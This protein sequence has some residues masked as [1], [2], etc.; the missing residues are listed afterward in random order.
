MALAPGSYVGVYEIL[1]RLDAGGMGEVYRARDP[2]LRRQVA[3]KV[4]P[5]A[6]ADDP[7]RLARFEREAQAVA[8]LSHPNILAIHD[9]GREGDIT[10]AVMEL[11][12]GHS[13]REMIDGGFIPR[14]K[15]I[16]CATQIAK[17]LE[18]AHARGIVH[19]D[20][21][22]EN[23]FVSAANRVKLLDFGLA[24]APAG[25]APNA[26]E[27]MSPEQ[28]RGE[29]VDHR[30]DIFS[31][32]RLLHELL[33][34]DASDPLAGV[35]ERCLEKTPAARFQ[36]ATDLLLALSAATATPAE[37]SRGRF[38]ALFAGALLLLA[39]LVTWILTRTA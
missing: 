9:Y 3:I 14:W 19:R 15:V 22:P 31:F 25:V 5:P 24:S 7:D 32:G 33:R 21:K 34:G 13:L 28:I 17:G 11:L 10:Y 36:S 30:A 6:F 12:D 39:V 1:A 23:V 29:P 38:A 2:K 4:L 16:D 8:A 18:A 20:L 35:V 26:A 37:R 27:Y